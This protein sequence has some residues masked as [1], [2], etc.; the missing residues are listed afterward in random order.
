MDE[1]VLT[2]HVTNAHAVYHVGCT[3][4]SED[5]LC[6]KQENSCESQSVYDIHKSWRPTEKKKLATLA[7][8]Y[9]VATRRGCIDN[10]S[11][12]GEFIWLHMQTQY[13]YLF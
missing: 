11:S 6:R 9:A 13:V 5:R 10:A 3:F 2:A 4:C 1:Y 8:V 12:D 7:L